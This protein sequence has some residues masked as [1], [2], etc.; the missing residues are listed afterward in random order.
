MKIRNCIHQIQFWSTY[1]KINQDNSKHKN[2]LL[3]DQKS[4]GPIVYTHTNKN[5]NTNNTSA[6]V[7]SSCIFLH[8]YGRDNGL[9]MRYLLQTKSHLP[10]EPCIASLNTPRRQQ[11]YLWDSCHHPEQGA[12]ALDC[13]TP[14]SS[15]LDHSWLSFQLSE[16]SDSDIQS[17]ANVH[18][19]KS[20]KKNF[21]LSF[22]LY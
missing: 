21:G 6:E 4:D 9:I 15:A 7:S 14:A 22:N 17:A 20:K 19:P 16:R 2:D 5:D 10:P 18:F 8:L 3:G 12:G 13:P 11:E 1:D